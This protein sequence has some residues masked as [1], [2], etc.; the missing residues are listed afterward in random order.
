MNNKEFREEYRMRMSK[1][2][3]IMVGIATVLMIAAIIFI[4]TGFHYLLE[5][6]NG[7]LLVCGIVG[8]FLFVISAY[9]IIYYRYIYK[10][11]RKKK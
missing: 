2:A 3:P 6:N 4:I 10:W 1:I 11:Y 9:G 8:G 7:A 5:G